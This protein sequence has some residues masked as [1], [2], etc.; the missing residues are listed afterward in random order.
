MKSYV[1]YEKGVPGFLVQQ[2][3]LQLEWRAKLSSLILVF[4]DIEVTIGTALQPGPP[5]SF[6]I[7]VVLTRGKG[8]ISYC[9]WKNVC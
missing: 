8:Q 9:I 5:K 2:T 7:C 6:L 3:H 4:S 1:F